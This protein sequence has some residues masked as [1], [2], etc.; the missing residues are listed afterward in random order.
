MKKTLAALAVLG[1]LAGSSMAADVTVYG[2][3]DTG[4]NYTHSKTDGIGALAVKGGDYDMNAKAD[5][6]TVDS[7]NNSATRWGLKG[8]EQIG[9]L[10][11]SFK[12]ENGFKADSG[13]L[14]TDGRIFDREATLAVGGAF[15]TVYA[16]RMGTLVSDTGSVGFYGAM[17]SSLGS[18][19]GD[20]LTGHTAVMANYASR[21]DNTIAYVT[22]EFAGLR[23]YAQYAMGNT[24][25]NKNTDDR[26]AA[27]GA[28]WNY[29]PFGVGALFDWL[30]KGKL[31]AYKG[32]A[33][34]NIQDQYTF[35]LAGSYDC[36]VAKTFLAVQYFKDARDAASIM[37]DFGLFDMGNA[38][39]QAYQKMT[40]AA[41]GYGVH[42]S[43][44][45]DALG[46]TWKAG[47]GYMDGD[48]DYADQTKVAD[49]KAYTLSLGY[50]YSLSKRTTLYSGAGY[51]KRE[52]DIDF[53]NADNRG[54]WSDK[55]Y[56]VQAGPVHRF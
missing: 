20:Y 43:T 27:V 39:D 17:A 10:S 46:G 22:P 12:L 9:D 6:F 23:V 11:V 31:A 29:G 19:W 3:I 51:V 41:S 4:L 40:T 16:G 34:P 32:D 55:V 2:V 44:Q 30:D 50:E 49:L 42:L 56:T 15:G 47:V 37:S 13:A 25:E 5:T 14:G 7:G 53:G 36:G 48:V 28:E 45:V 8:T 54:D 1:A 33:D 18:G 21:Y 38:G 24:N 26:Y 52:L 35:N